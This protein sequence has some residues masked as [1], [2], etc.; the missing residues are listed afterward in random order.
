LKLV[1]QNDQGER[2][3][4]SIA[5]A[6][7]LADDY[8]LTVDADHGR[9]TLTGVL[10]LPQDVH[11]AVALA[12]G[13]DGVKGVNHSADFAE[14]SAVIDAP[15]IDNALEESA[16]TTLSAP[17]WIAWKTCCIGNRH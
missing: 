12:A 13:I 14:R 17:C 9:I 7:G 3:R 1:E 15:T 5:P 11:R 10:A 8:P 6:D 4:K 16:T 2:L